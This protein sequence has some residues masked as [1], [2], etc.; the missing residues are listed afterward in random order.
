VSG[1]DDD[2]L[3]LVMTRCPDCQQPL[4]SWRPFCPFCGRPQPPAP[5]SA[6]AIWA[7]GPAVPT[8]PPSDPHDTTPA[9]EAPPYQNDVADGA[10]TIV[11]PGATTAETDGS[12]DVAQP[13][14]RRSRWR[15]EHTWVTIIAA[16][17]ICLAALAWLPHPR[18]PPVDGRLV[19]RVS[20]PDG[21]QLTAGDVFIAG[22]DDKTA[23]PGTEISLPPGTVN[24]HYEGRVKEQQW[25]T[26]P[27]QAVIV[28]GQAVLLDLKA[29]LAPAIVDVFTDPAGGDI[30]LDGQPRGPSPVRLR[31]EDGLHELT[32]KHD[33]L[34]RTVT[35]SARHGEKRVVTISLIRTPPRSLNR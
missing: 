24:V 4:A 8:F 32:G 3:S 30:M 17:L 15:S 28:S 12:E 22:Q 25:E 11:P 27:R 1:D 34:S 2:T 26:S 33:G 10:S 5:W 7:T 23:P 16:S 21:S 13:P 29:T 35:Y 14:A 18:T 6:E 19:V 31:L 20:H 9:I